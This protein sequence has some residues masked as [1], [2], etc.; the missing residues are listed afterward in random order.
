M[1]FLRV[2]NRRIVLWQWILCVNVRIVG[3]MYT[4]RKL[5]CQKCSDFFLINRKRNDKFTDN[6]LLH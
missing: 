4:R 1:G 3:T 5:Y 6:H 2:R